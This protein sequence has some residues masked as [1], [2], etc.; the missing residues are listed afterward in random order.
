MADGLYDVKTSEN[1][2]PGSSRPMTPFPEAVPR[3]GAIV[4]APVPRDAREL[5]AHFTRRLKS[6]LDPGVELRFGV[7]AKSLLLEGRLY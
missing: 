5:G 6:A 2:V 4:L 7:P 3:Y 1:A